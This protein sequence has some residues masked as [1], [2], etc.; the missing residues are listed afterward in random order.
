[1]VK[2]PFILLLFAVSTL[3]CAEENAFP[4]CGIT[5]RE[6]IYRNFDPQ[7]SAWTVAARSQII[8]KTADGIE[9]AG[10]K[11]ELEAVSLLKS[12][13]NL[14]N[15]KLKQL[16]GVVVAKRCVHKDFVYVEIKVDANSVR[17]SQTLK[18]DMAK[19]FAENPTPKSNT[20]GHDRKATDFNQ[21]EELI[22]KM[23]K[24]TQ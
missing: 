19:S 8:S 22:K 21:L 23:Q 13:I 1:M 11:A 10:E 6:G 7:N 18:D 24:K 5:V 15:K 14:D 4:S 16:S 17:V 9:L 3:I 2:S 12:R 20:G